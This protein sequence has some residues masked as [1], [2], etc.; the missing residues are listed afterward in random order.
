MSKSIDPLKVTSQDLHRF[1]F[2]IS[3]EKQWYAVMAECRQWFGNNWRAQGKVRRKFESFGSQRLR[4]HTIWFEVPDSKFATWI[5]VKYSI[6]VHSDTKLK[7]N[8]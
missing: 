7:T 1:W 5:S 3:N 6:Q 2:S 4:S 8:K